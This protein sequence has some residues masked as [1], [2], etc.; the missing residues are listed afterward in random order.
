MNKMTPSQ[1]VKLFA[2]QH[3]MSVNNSGG[4]PMLSKGDWVDCFDNWKHALEFLQK[5]VI[6]KQDKNISA[7]WQ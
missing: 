2:R 1:Q 5:A 4:I 7:P 6:A 3:G